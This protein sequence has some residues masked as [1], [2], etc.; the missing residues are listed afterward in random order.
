MVVGLGVGMAGLPGC[1]DGPS[2]AN[3]L[4][5]TPTDQ[6]AVAVSLRFENVRTFLDANG[7]ES[8]NEWSQIAPILTKYHQTGNVYGVE[9]RAEPI[10]KSNAPPGMRVHDYTVRMV[11]ANM[12]RLAAM[13]DEISATRGRTIGGQRI[14]FAAKNVE[15][16]YSTP[17]VKPELEMSFFGRGDPGTT[18]S[19]FEPGMTTPRVQTI[20]SAGIWTIRLRVDPRIEH[21]YGYSTGADGQESYFR[22]HVLSRTHE[23]LNRESFMQLRFSGN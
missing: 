12:S 17:Y 5:G 6:V 19:L 14:D 16:M 15:V 13:H 20:G 3:V 18:V 9:Y 10:A 11:V 22:I 2:V 8:G 23:A 21:I 1:A 4:P 7:N